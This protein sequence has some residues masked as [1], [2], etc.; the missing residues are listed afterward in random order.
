MHE[1][2]ADELA[3]LRGDMTPAYVAELRAKLDRMQYVSNAFYGHA[4]MIGV[5]PFIEFCG[6]MNEWI[7]LA[8]AALDAGIDYSKINVHADRFDGLPIEPYHAAYLG[9]KFGCIFEQWLSTPELVQAFLHGAGM[10]NKGA[11]HAGG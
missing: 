1:W 11:E 4:V 10:A 8:S 6:F 2:T 7:K 9:E 5:H 3:Q